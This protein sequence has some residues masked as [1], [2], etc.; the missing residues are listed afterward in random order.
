VNRLVSGLASERAVKFLD[1]KAT[2]KAR[3]DDGLT[4]EKGGLVIEVTVDGEK[5]PFVLAVGNLEPDKSAYY[6]TANRQGDSLFTVRK[7]VFEKPKEKPAFFN[8]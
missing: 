6:A 2:P 7:D 3:E 8:P 1:V 5:E 4:P